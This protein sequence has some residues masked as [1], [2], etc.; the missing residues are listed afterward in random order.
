M[1]DHSP[2]PPHGGLQPWANKPQAEPDGLLAGR[3]GGWWNAFYANRARPVPFFGPE[4]DESLSQWIA[5][6]VIAPGKA[7]DL[8]CG[9]GRNAVF[10]AKSGFSVDGVD[11]APTA[12]EWAAQRANEAGVEV[13][14]HTASVFDIALPPASFDLV[15]GKITPARPA[16]TQAPH[17]PR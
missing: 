5:G 11:V 7:V 3:A 2:N 1:P 12:I 15:Y 13:R 16:T 14:L 17:H 6:G 9:N 10:L 4:P 8:G